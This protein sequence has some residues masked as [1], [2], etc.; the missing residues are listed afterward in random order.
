MPRNYEGGGDYIQSDDPLNLSIFKYSCRPLGHSRTRHM[1]EQE[2]KEAHSYI[3]LNC[4]EV[5]PYVR[6]IFL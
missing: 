1:I 2:Y 4:E 5:E 3:L 6:L